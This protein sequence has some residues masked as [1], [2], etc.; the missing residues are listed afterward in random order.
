MTGNCTWDAFSSLGVCSSCEDVSN[1]ITPTCSGSSDDDNGSNNTC[2]ELT[3][4]LADYNLTIV[5]QNGSLIDSQETSHGIHGGGRTTIKDKQ[6]TLVK[7][8][9]GPSHPGGLQDPRM[10]E[11][12]M[13]QLLV[14]S[15]ANLSWNT[16]DL[17]TPSW[18]LTA[19]AVSWCAK[20]YDNVKV[21]RSLP[22]HP[23]MW[24]QQLTPQQQNG[25]L[26][27]ASPR[28]VDL[29]A[30]ANSTCWTTSTCQEFAATNASSLPAADANATFAIAIDSD[31]I[32]VRHILDFDYNITVHNAS[33][34]DSS[35]SAIDDAYTLATTMMWNTD[36]AASFRHIAASMT[37]HMRDASA[38]ADASNDGSTSA[39]RILGTATHAVT[40]VVVSWPWFALPAA[41]VASG[42][43]LLLIC[44]VLTARGK[45]EG[46]VWKSASLPLLLL[47]LPGGRAWRE[48][49]WRRGRGRGRI[50]VQMA[51]VKGRLRADERGV[52]RFVSN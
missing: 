39:S 30:S 24:Q 19:C 22:T 21:V 38:L 28:D 47:G 31:S 9:V 36:I 52:V 16:D 45:K 17:Q 43:A 25:A 37:A 26:T 40:F 5:L 12:I 20:A 6:Y 29:T 32:S 50:G 15:T 7:S 3:Y 44:V 42:L 48:E 27:N 2:S 4:T 33:D 10:F 51:G 41:V 8:V 11:F 35:S 34:T 1:T 46:V 49:E 23:H 13:A 18:N 14:N